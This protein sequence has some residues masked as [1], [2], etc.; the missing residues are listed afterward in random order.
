M[1]I[2][3][4][5]FFLLLFHSL[6]QAQQLYNEYYY[7]NCSVADYTAN[8]TFEINLNSLLPILIFNARFVYYFYTERGANPDTIYGLFL[9]RGDVT[10]NTCNACVN[11]S[12][13]DIKQR[14]P[15]R[16][17]AVIWYDHCM[18]RY[19]DR[20]FKSVYDPSINSI[21][22]T[23]S[24][25]NTTDPQPFNQTLNS[26]LRNLSSVAAFNPSVRMSAMGE[27][28]FTA[29]QKIYAIVQCTPD[30]SENDCYTCLLAAISEIPVC[31][32]GR[33]GAVIS[34]AS[35]AM[36]Y[37][38]LPFYVGAA[39][40]P[41]PPPSSPTDSS[42]GNG[43]NQSKIIIFISVASV[44]GLVLFSS[45]IY[46]FC[47]RR[48]RKRSRKV[49]ENSHHELLNYLG[50]PIGSE[51]LYSSMNGEQT[52]DLPLIDL[53]TIQAAT[54]NFSDGNKLGEG[55]F[56][57]VYKGMLPDGK[58]IAV[59]RLSKSSGQ[60]LEEFKNEVTLIA[61]LQHRN[62]VR[63]MYCCIERGEKL[64]I[65]EYMPN[66]SLDVFLF[67]PVK[68]AQLGWE[69]CQS[70]IGGIAKGLV[71]LHEDS[72]LRIIHRDLKS[73]NI[74]LDHEMNPK[75]SDFGM[76]RFL[77]GN[78]SQVN[79]NK[80]VGTYGYMAPEYAMGGRFSVKSDVYSFGVLLLE[81]LSGKRNNGLNLP[82]HAQSLLTYAWELWCDG[83]ALKLIDSLLAQTCPTSEVLRW[84][85]IG[86]L[87]VQEDAADR[88]TMSSVV[89]MLGSESMDLPQPTQPGFF[90]S[91]VVNESD[92]SSGSAKIRSLNEVTIST[93]RPR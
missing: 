31:C 56:G 71:Y 27:A 93:L 2:F 87:C 17:Q 58:E 41:R 34:G 55:G 70:I 25:K 6:S 51:L 80:V 33:D 11:Q 35:C 43:G 76:A 82:N 8:T 65:Y 74:L 42:S 83:K 91:R 78:Q 61:K 92:Q 57:P 68:R 28:N 14:C 39:S 5:S 53:V 69:R 29:S 21:M 90:V 66:T 64:L 12:T 86:L 40:V 7:S 37:D 77:R 73:S 4:L 67:D 88:P 60:G 13:Q 44:A 52:Q 63:L 50:P 62:L 20:N 22:L 3:Q 49:K 19:S 32:D 24:S 30:L 85:H 10:F 23:R 36:R 9:C 48:Q 47:Y 54:N 81:I 16:K 26:L 79:T 1:H 75:I 18:L 59:K 15:N 89:L 72:R 46:C 45:C 84:I 38:V